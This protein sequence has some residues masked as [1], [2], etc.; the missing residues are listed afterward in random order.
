M[1]GNDCSFLNG[2]EGLRFL[3]VPHCI[4]KFRNVYSF[5][6]LATTQGRAV[7]WIFYLFFIEDHLFPLVT[8]VFA[9]L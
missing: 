9:L 8:N 5:S 2:D 3:E 4:V 6:S 7:Q 1:T